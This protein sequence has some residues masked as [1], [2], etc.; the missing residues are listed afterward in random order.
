MAE[1]THTNTKTALPVSSRSLTRPRGH[2]HIIPVT[3]LRR[4]IRLNERHAGLV[5]MANELHVAK[6]TVDRWRSFVKNGQFEAFFEKVKRLSKQ[7]QPRKLI[8]RP[9]VTERAAAFGK[10]KLPAVA[11]KIAQY[12]AQGMKGR[13]IAAK[14]HL[15]PAQIWYWLK[16]M[17]SSQDSKSSKG[18]V[19]GIKSNF[20]KNILLGIA[21][22]E[23]ERFIANLAQRIKVPPQVLRRRL[24]ELLGH[25]PLWD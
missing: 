19:N 12:R 11:V 8:H 23:T 18:D 3:T 14:V 13:E 17:N 22:A 21:Y 20:N 24:P 25:S 2:G 5:E 7:N 1:E 15:S 10:T 4:F 6:S 9:T 16:K